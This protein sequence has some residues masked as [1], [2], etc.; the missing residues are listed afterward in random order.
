MTGKMSQE[1]LGMR[2]ILKIKLNDWLV[3]LRTKIGA[4]L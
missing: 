2:I 1:A 3:M 4:L